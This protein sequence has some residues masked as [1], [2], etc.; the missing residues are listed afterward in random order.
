M[1]QA[2]TDLDRSELMQM[3][4]AQRVECGI[5]LEQIRADAVYLKLLIDRQAVKPDWEH[6]LAARIEYT[7]KDYPT[8]FGGSDAVERPK[9]T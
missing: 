9:T 5:L 3:V 2:L 8:L 7:L 4:L 6:R 1:E